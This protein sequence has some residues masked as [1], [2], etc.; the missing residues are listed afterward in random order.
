MISLFAIFMGVKSVKLIMQELLLKSMQFK[1]WLSK[2]LFLHNLLIRV[3]K[4]KFHVDH[5]KFMRN[6][7]WIAFEYFFIFTIGIFSKKIKNLHLRVQILEIVCKLSNHFFP[8]NLRKNFLWMQKY[9]NS[10]FQ[11]FF[12]FHDWKS[13]QFPKF[14]SIFI[15]VI[16]NVYKVS[17]IFTISIH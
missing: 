7:L 15:F 16:K 10:P 14:L 2:I 5:L 11:I 17:K 4:R 6:I 13:V 3:N 12:Y 8:K 1:F 9:K